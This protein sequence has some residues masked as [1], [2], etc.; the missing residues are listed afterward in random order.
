MDPWG[1]G[2]NRNRGGGG[3]GNPP[4]L[5]EL[6]KKTQDRMKTVLPGG[7]GGGIGF[8]GVLIVLGIGIVGWLA[9]GIYTVDEGERGVELVLGEVRRHYVS[10]FQLQ[11]A[12]SDW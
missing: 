7:G 2:P 9:T 10:G 12:L 6:L 4:D 5:E 1:G 3:G 11:S 8:A